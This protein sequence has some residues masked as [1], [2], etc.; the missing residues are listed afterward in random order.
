MLKR[1]CPSCL[2]GENAAE[3]FAAVQCSTVQCNAVPSPVHL[4]QGR[5]GD[6]LCR[7]THTLGEAARQGGLG[8]W[9]CWDIHT[10]G[11]AATQGG[12]GA[13]PCWG[14]HTL[15]MSNITGSKSSPNPTLKSLR[16]NS[17]QHT[18]T[19]RTTPRVLSGQ[20]LEGR[21]NETCHSCSVS[22]G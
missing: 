12:L 19:T 14:I 2:Y 5:L 13:W 18:T 8:A 7:Y 11:E 1:V 15:G 20:C 16:L 6:F 3:A 21:D 9:L 17:C 4:Q 10:L 22:L